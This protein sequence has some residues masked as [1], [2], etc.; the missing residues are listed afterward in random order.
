MSDE[1]QAQP[2]QTHPEQSE[3]PRCARDSDWCDGVICREHGVKCPNATSSASP[4]RS[5]GTYRRRE[6]LLKAHMNELCPETPKN[7]KCP[8]C[9]RWGAANFVTVDDWY[10]RPPAPPC[11]PRRRWELLLLLVIVAFLVAYGL[12]HVL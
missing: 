10:P 9:D 2:E 7:L 6:L 1:I 8:V 4:G 5:T 11:Q 12:A 3:R